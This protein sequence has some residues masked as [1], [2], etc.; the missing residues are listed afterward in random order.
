M[1]ERSGSAAT[2]RRTGSS[3]N[4][5]KRGRGNNVRLLYT[6]S[7]YCLH[8]GALSNWESSE[9]HIRAAILIGQRTGREALRGAPAQNGN[10]TQE[11]DR[12]FGERCEPWIRSRIN[13][14][15]IYDP[16]CNCIIATNQN[17][18][19]GIQKNNS[20]CR[21]NSRETIT[22]NHCISFATFAPDR[23]SSYF[24]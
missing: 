3:V 4:I 2:G 15:C 18:L 7:V 16:I 23:K 21:K 24:V 12:F 11:Y 20:S 5:R 13:I 19:H 8:E 14:G 9:R 17:L 6:G 22:H 1:L 10:R